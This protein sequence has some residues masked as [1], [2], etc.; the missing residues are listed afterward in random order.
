[1]AVRARRA[2]VIDVLDDDRLL[3]R[4][5]ALKDD[6]N[7]TGLRWVRKRRNKRVSHFVREFP[8]VRA[9]RKALAP[10]FALDPRCSRSPAERPA[11]SR[12]PARRGDAEVAASPI[13]P[14]PE[15]RSPSFACRHP[16]VV[17]YL[18]ELDHLVRAWKRRMPP[19]RK[20]LFSR[21]G[22]GRFD[23]EDPIGV[24][25][26]CDSSGYSLYPTW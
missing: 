24:F 16:S 19:R 21:G 14:A 12:P 20:A 4:I 2:A 6:N 26:V 15:R 8:R 18:E 23:P 11:L 5:A 25:S 7:L 13:G 3:A 22:R 1:M 17:A 9:R 10:V